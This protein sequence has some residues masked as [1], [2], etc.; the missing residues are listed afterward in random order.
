V[1]KFVDT[2]LQLDGVEEQTFRAE[3]DKMEISQKEEI[4]QVTTSWEQKG[5][6]MGQR[7]LL[8]RLL[9]R[10]VG[11]VSEA[12]VEWVNGLSVRQLEALGDAL[13]DFRSI[14]DLQRW[15]SRLG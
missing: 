1:S 13:L 10:K 14:D 6:E 11:G 5:I 12:M 2:Y 3:V 4:M 7:S 15:F 8:L 9:D